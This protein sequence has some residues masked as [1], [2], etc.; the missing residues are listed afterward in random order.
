ME[1]TSVL[2][3]IRET[4]HELPA[5][6]KLVVVFAIVATSPALAIL[7]VMMGMAMFPLVLAGRFEGDLGA[8]PL[9]HDLESA[10]HHQEACTR[11][12]YAT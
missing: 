7:A 12:Y 10:I 4:F 9:K 6:Q 5:W 1:R 3:I 8:S 11:H 2:G